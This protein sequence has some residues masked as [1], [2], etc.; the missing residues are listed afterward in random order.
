M[1]AWSPFPFI[2]Y[3]IALIAGILLYEFSVFDTHLV[4][5]LI[6]SC[7]VLS[8]II[9]LIDRLLFSNDFTRL[10]FGLI[11][12]SAFC[13]VGYCCSVLKNE[14]SLANHYSNYPNA[15]AFKGVILS[16]NSERKD[17]Q[18][19]ELEIETIKTTD[20]ALAVTGKIF[21]Y[22]RKKESNTIYQY[23]DRLNVLVSYHEVGPPGN[24]EEFNY[25]DYLEKQNIFCHA[26]ASES[27][28]ENLGNDPP[29]DLLARAYQIRARC[30]QIIFEHLPKPREQAILTALLIGIKDHL[31]NDTKR[32]YASAGAMHVLA[33]SGLHVGI[34]YYLI[35]MI[36]G[37]IKKK[38]FGKPL[39]IAMAVCLIWAY[40][41]VTGFSPSVLRAAVMFSIVLISETISKTPN[42]YN[43]L[44]IAA[45]ILLLY[46]PFLIHSVGFQLS[47]A[48]VF[49]IVFL[50]P[51]LVRL[52]TPSGF[53][54]KY[55]WA[56]TCVSISAQLATFPLTVYYFH[57]FPT[58]FLVSNIIVIPTAAVVLVGGIVLILA[59]L[60][61][62][63]LGQVIGYALF[64]IIWVVNELV[65]FLTLLPLP[66]VDWLYFD[67]YD[68]ALVYALVILLSLAFNHYHKG[69]FRLGVA[70]LFVLV[71]WINTKFY[72]HSQQKRM[73]IYE[74]KDHIAIDFV[75]GKKAILLVDKIEES[76]I[77]VVGFQ[78]NPFR[79][80]NGL[81]KMEQTFEIMN[82][83]DLVTKME[84]G[85]LI[86]WDNKRI[87]ILDSKD[88]L[89][90]TN[91]INAD[92]VYLDHTKYW[93]SEKIKAETVIVGANTQY[94][95][96]EALKNRLN[97]VGIQ[98]H[99]LVDDG[100][101]E[102]KM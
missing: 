94:Y 4:I 6:A 18:R 5:I 74:I 77:E 72:Y 21:L 81:P 2:R 7:I 50:Q 41:L 88:N 26:F 3:A 83:S 37:F 27:D 87:V 91:E 1:F 68:T 45:F 43:S 25:K 51:K 46:D 61:N 62:S 101:Y 16:D 90:F 89:D 8:T 57:Q 73:I 100:Y 93:H 9:W 97:D 13:F 58:Y 52:I 84:Y 76:E 98:A 65:S 40:A 15:I 11:T 22:V 47:F 34:V 71:I 64:G 17:Y 20:S 54:L 95:N 86:H 66:I 67:F 38:K 99:S 49:G 60:I 92:I 96:L 36:F 102:V 82:Q 63:F 35:N 14:R 56:I 32:A 23:G 42:I 69:A 48:A 24:P 31:D 28:I 33:V 55:L 85:Y 79:L 44:G 39:F 75:E 53:I 10:F 80:A 19:Y 78:V 30:K 12:L 29:S 59:A 70:V